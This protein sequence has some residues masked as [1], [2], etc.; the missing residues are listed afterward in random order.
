MDERPG[1][2]RL[3]EAQRM[4][5]AVFAEVMARRVVGPNEIGRETDFARTVVLGTVRGG[6]PESRG[7]GFVPSAFAQFLG[8]S[9]AAGTGRGYGVRFR[10]SCRFRRME[11]LTMSV[12]APYL[13]FSYGTLQLEQVQLA[14]FGRLLEGAPDALPGY[15]TSVVRI[16][17]PD[18][19]AASGSDLHP[20]VVLS[21]D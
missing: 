3:V 11:G 6:R 10:G 4:V 8:R 17:D 21:G 2:F 5:Q 7:S 13:L 14:R 15:T 1:A 9:D 16:A 20:V 18:V 19:I 12:A